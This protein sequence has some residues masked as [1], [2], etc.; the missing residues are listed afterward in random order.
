MS[1]LLPPSRR[2]LAFMLMLGAT[3]ILD[4]QVPPLRP[5][6]SSALPAYH[7]KAQVRGVLEIP[8]TDSLASMGHRWNQG[9]KRFHPASSL[10]YLPRLT[11][12]A[13]K[14]FVEGGRSLVFSA[15][16]MTPEEKQR[17]K[18]KFGYL[19]M[20]IPVCMDANVVFVNKAN[21]IPAITMEQLDAIY[22]RDRKGGRK[23]AIR[24]WGDLGV[25][26]SLAGRPITAYLREEGSA[27]RGAFA[28]A[29]LL[30]GE[31]RSGLVVR[32]DSASLAESV[33]A[34]PAGIAFG[35]MAALEPANKVLPVVPFQGSEARLPTQDQ[36]TTSRYPMP[37]L[38]FAYVHRP[39]GQPLPPL[40]DE[41]L[42]FLLSRE[43][44]GTVA[45]GGLFPGPM[46]FL[47][48]A[49]KRLDR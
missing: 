6:V 30:G 23:E 21:P 36:V 44:Q 47:A 2:L 28:S 4:G 34:D 26:G 15:R 37:M 35:P 17:F 24:T 45:E 33:Q 43:G 22:G 46:E 42:H 5:T 11:R 18:G 32:G 40:V 3:G 20:R 16:E 8:G 29:A 27:I 19:P 41:F 9:F 7:P 1:S 12:D 14:E 39:P 25:A 31:F 49:L 10:V 48:I 38:Y 13:L